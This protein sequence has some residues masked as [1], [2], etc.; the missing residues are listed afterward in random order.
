[1]AGSGPGPM[2]TG[3][4]HNIFI[5]RWAVTKLD[6]SVISIGDMA[7]SQVKSTCEVCGEPVACDD[8]P[9]GEWRHASLPEGDG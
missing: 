9:R 6:G 1:M 5:N 8:W 2:R 4:A 7:V 3:T